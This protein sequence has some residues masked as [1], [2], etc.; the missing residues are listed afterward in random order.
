MESFFTEDRTDITEEVINEFL[1]DAKKEN[2][3]Y[4]AD[5]ADS[6]AES[7]PSPGPDSDP[8]RGSDR[9]GQYGSS[10]NADSQSDA[11]SDPDKEARG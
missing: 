10:P 9:P 8:D 6:D 5:D 2:V 4:K 7:D 11:C 3:F 1:E